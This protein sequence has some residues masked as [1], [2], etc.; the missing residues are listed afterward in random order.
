[1]GQRHVSHGREYRTSRSHGAGVTIARSRQSRPHGESK[2]V[3]CTPAP[4]GSQ[5]LVCRRFSGVGP[6]GI[7]KH[8]PNSFCDVLATLG[9]RLGPVLFAMGTSKGAVLRPGLPARASAQDE[10]TCPPTRKSIHCGS[11]WLNA[12]YSKTKLTKRTLCNVFASVGFEP[13]G[14]TSVCIPEYTHKSGAEGEP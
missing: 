2:K 13:F 3:R 5:A 10:R 1:M 7:L 4:S 14:F 12:S 8:P 11:P 9:G 6:S